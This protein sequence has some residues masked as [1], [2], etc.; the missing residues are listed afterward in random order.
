MLFSDKKINNFTII[1]DDV[2]IKQVESTKF[3]GVHTLTKN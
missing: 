1:V 2:E 3:L